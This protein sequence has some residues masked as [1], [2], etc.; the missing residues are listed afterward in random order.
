[1]SEW[2]DDKQK[3]PVLHRWD[4]WTFLEEAD[5]SGFDAMV[6]TNRELEDVKGSR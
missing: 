4:T 1:M 2:L 3:S 5:E 6:L